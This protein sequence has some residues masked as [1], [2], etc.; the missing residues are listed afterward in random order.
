[1]VFVYFVME[2][3]TDW[4]KGNCNNVPQSGKF[5]TIEVYSITILNSRIEVWN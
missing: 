1:M 4:N 5:T 3:R 2:A